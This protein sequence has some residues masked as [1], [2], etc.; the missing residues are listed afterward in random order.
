MWLEWLAPHAT[1]SRSEHDRTGE[2]NA[3][4]PMK[5]QLMGREAVMAITEGRL[6]FGPREQIFYASATAGDGNAC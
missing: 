3:D 4:A 6:D 2:D 1:T 5:R